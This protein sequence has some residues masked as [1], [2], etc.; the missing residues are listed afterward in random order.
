VIISG[1]NASVISVSVAGIRDFALKSG[2]NAA[3]SDSLAEA[4]SKILQ[5]LKTVL[6]GSDYLISRKSESGKILVHIDFPAGVLPIDSGELEELPSWIRDAA[7]GTDRAFIGRKRRMITIQLVMYQ[8]I[9]GKEGEPW[10]MGLTPALN[11]TVHIDDIRTGQTE[12]SSETVLEN[13]ETGKVLRL[14][15]ISAFIVSKMNGYKN[16]SDI[17]LEA[18]DQFGLISPDL[19]GKLYL[20]LE[21][22]GMLKND[23]GVRP[24]HRIAEKLRELLEK[25]Y[26]F[27]RSNEMLGS[28]LTKAGVLA[29]PLGAFLLAA[30]G[31]AGIAVLFLNFSRFVSVFHD[32]APYMVHHPVVLIILYAFVFLT[33]IMHELGHG[34]T[35][36]R[37][38]GRVDR[39]GFMLYL[40]MFIF[41][42][43]VSSTWSMK[44]RWHRIKVELGGPLVTFGILG[45][46]IIGYQVV[47][48]PSL[49]MVFATAA[50]MEIFVLVMNL[51]PFLRM[52]AYYV[53]EDILNVTNLR[54]NSFGFWKGI[55]FRDRRLPLRSQITGRNR[56]IYILYGLFGGIFTLVFVA[57]S[58][59]Y[60]GRELLFHQGSEGKIV[61][62]AL[63]IL[64]FLIRFGMKIANEMKSRTHWME[65]IN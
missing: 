25:G 54:R 32:A 6:N 33:T 18:V 59:F 19:P 60:Y 62:A 39:M 28:I 42:C 61:M 58:L 53:L 57:Y 16:L 11:D 14:D 63:V 5:H 55:V 40:V 2:L 20:A 35:C 50:M 45:A 27:R 10:F 44:N 7:K 64:I 24:G 34:L 49:A 21:S 1:G 65:E 51:N 56:A 37:L 48:S 23:S 38:G 41:F 47:S 13:T 46:C 12:T 4:V 26:S 36:K 52:D 31:I 3:L 43:D 8:R 17:F 29:G 22:N 15:Y 30:S 9:K